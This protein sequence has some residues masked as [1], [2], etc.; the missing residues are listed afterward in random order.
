MNKTWWLTVI[1]VIT[2]CLIIGCADHTSPIKESSV[3]ASE[4]TDIDT[5][6]S[7][8]E[9][10][11]DVSTD[12]TASEKTTTD[13][14][15][16][17]PAYSFNIQTAFQKHFFSASNGVSFPYRLYIPEET[18]SL[19]YPVLLYLHGAGNRG[20]DNRRQLQEVGICFEN[21]ASPAFSSIVIAPQCPTDMWWSDKFGTVQALVELFD[22][23][24]DTYHTDPARR[25]VTGGSM[26]GDGVWALISQYPK[27]FTAALPAGGSGIM[28]GYDEQGCLVPLNL[29][30]ALMAMPICQVYDVN[31]N[32]IPAAHYQYLNHLLYEAGASNYTYR[33]TKGYGHNI[34]TKFISKDDISLLLWLYDQE[35]IP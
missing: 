5:V 10:E 23:I 34:C 12:E 31:D 24:N 17:A 4:T 29:T 1:C 3:E 20:S 9:T 6:T 22:H 35:R 30:D 15:E 18:A 14:P 7:N 25:Y 27:K 26:G 19:S 13:E 8:E 21:V 2:L 32:V 16:T 33:E 11:F 28:I